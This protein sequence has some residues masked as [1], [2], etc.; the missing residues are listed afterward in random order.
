MSL[1]QAIPEL[2]GPQA[3]PGIL[4]RAAH[5]MPLYEIFGGVAM[6]VAAETEV[7]EMLPRPSGDPLQTCKALVSI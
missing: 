4:Q 7:A 2:K 1:E 5:K 6:G 3:T